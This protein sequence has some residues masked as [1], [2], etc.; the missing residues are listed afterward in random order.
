MKLFEHLETTPPH[1]CSKCGRNLIIGREVFYHVNI[2]TLADPNFAQNNEL[3]P[4]E[5]TQSLNQLFTK[6]HSL[7][8]VEAE[9]RVNSTQNHVLCAQ[10]H[11][12]WIEFPFG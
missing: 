12:E 6:L 1:Q 10:C 11:N 7:S 3:S 8:A 4:E 5:I 2:Q 9:E